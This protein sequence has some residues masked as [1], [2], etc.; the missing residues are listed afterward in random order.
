MWVCRVVDET[1]TH[2]S[3]TNRTEF[4]C[5]I[6]KFNEIFQL[7]LFLSLEKFSKFQVRIR[8]C[9][10]NSVALIASHTFMPVASHSLARDV[11]TFAIYDN[12]T[13]FFFAGKTCFGVQGDFATLCQPNANRF[14]ASFEYFASIWVSSAYNNEILRLNSVE[15]RFLLHFLNW[16]AL[17]CAYMHI[18]WPKFVTRPRNEWMS[19]NSLHHLVR[20]FWRLLP[21]R[22]NIHVQ[23]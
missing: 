4:L 7:F 17:L 18:K 16:N 23:Q 3:F 10:T 2:F 21:M 13:R 22:I 12:H 14:S 19:F 8:I 1:S 9:K 5:H 20:S 6:Y 11:H 15:M